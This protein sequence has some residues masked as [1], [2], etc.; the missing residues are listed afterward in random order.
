MEGT[1]VQ[2]LNDMK[3]LLNI[4][5]GAHIVWVAGMAGTGKTSIALT[6][7]RM[8][9]NEPDILLGGTFFC[10]RAAG[11]VERTE[12]ERI[13]PTF[14]TLM[15]R[16]VLDYAEALAEELKD[17]PDLA[18]K[19]I[20]LQ[21]EHLLVKPLESVALLD[22]QIVFVVDALDECSNEERL[23]E[24]INAL[25]NFACSAPVKFLF[26]SRSEMHI[27]ETAIADKSLSSI[28]HLHTIDP[29]LVT[30]DI[31][32]YIQRT[33]DKV[34]K[35][36]TWYTQDDIDELAVSS[37]G[38]FIFA[39]TAIAYILEHK[40]VPGRVKR[41]QTV[42]TQIS[43]S[44]IATAPLDKMYS[45]V[46]M[47]ASDPT[48]F[49]PAELDEMRRIIAVILC[50]RAP[51]TLNCLAEILGLTPEDLRG[52]LER[53]H[54]VI[55]VPEEDDWGELRTLHASFG[56][57]MFTRAPEH[58]RVCKGFGHDEL[59]RGCLERMSADDLCFNIS[60]GST[61]YT[62][63]PG[64]NLGEIASSLVYACLHWAYHVDLASVRSSFDEK[65]YSFLQH[66]LLFWLE[67]LNATWDVR[68][69][70][71]LLHITASAV[72]SYPVLP[73]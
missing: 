56:D 7:C 40:S 42:K 67:L 19:A 6:L 57:F 5:G 48:A 68:R 41:L 31:R 33:F 29:T 38:L 72:C 11:A 45:L 69:A 20:A 4:R 25:A 54:T 23:V 39:S 73:R 63:N 28:V 13:I 34:T 55:F 53:L 16:S 60:R 32:L 9:A 64:I 1:R 51:L 21:L 70:S 24:L 8:L 62:A 66:K 26:T 71:S 49:E 43:D 3:S 65:I 35:T 17:D 47:Q 30:A 37:G 36:A 58:I 12:A 2:I 27:R 22:R 46:L 50:T 10:S 52:A 44:T 61:S 18:H 14:A 59:A 15:A